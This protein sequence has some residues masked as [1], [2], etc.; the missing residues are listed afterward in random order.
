MTAMPTSKQGCIPRLSRRLALG[1]FAGFV[2]CAPAPGIGSEPRVQ[3][4]C[5][6]G[7]RVAAQYV[8]DPTGVPLAVVRIEG[9]QR[10]LA[11]AMS[12]SGARYL[13]REGL[14]P[15]TRLVWWTKGDE[16]LVLT[17]ASDLPEFEEDLVTR[18]LEAG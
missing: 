16:A 2:A 12:A 13:T 17:G 15:D 9:K 10:T 8:I 14:E 4:A 1:A 11:S 3:Y 6:N 18:C 5:E 7:W